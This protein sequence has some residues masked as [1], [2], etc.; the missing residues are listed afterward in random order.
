MA[1]GPPD[2]RAGVRVRGSVMQVLLLFLVL[3]AATA[4]TAGKRDLAA[5]VVSHVDG[6]TLWVQVTLQ[7][8]KMTEMACHTLYSDQRNDPEIYPGVFV[9][10]GCEVAV[11]TKVRL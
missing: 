8:V 5:T 1:V 3:V 6:D 10:P 7:Q 4:R 11:F 9:M 2:S